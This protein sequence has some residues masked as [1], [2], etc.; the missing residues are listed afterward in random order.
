MAEAFEAQESPQGGAEFIT[1]RA[2]RTV[3][4]A[5]EAFRARE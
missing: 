3:D 1:A 2:A 4:H 5:G